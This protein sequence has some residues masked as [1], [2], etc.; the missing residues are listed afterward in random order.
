MGICPVHCRRDDGGCTPLLF[1]YTLVV[2]SCGYLT[3]ERAV[4]SFIS[5]Y[6]MGECRKLEQALQGLC[7]KGS[8]AKLLV[9]PCYLQSVV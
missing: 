4:G 2:L 1:W 8:V 9:T 7:Q 3:E 6:E 5:R